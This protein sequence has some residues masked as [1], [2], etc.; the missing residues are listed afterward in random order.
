[1]KI[2]LFNLS[3]IYAT[4]NDEQF[5]NGK[6]AIRLSEKLCSLQDY[7]HPLSLDALAAAYA[8]IGKFDT[9][10]S[11]AKKAVELA[12]LYGPNELVSGINKRISLYKSGQPYRQVPQKKIYTETK[13][14]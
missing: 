4:N 2:A 13:N 6:E 5:R 8:E 12:L 11:T 14:K 1:M 3:W 10:V 7:K 9:A